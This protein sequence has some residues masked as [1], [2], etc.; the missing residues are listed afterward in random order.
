MIL[1]ESYK[2]FFCEAAECRNKQAGS[3]VSENGWRPLHTVHHNHPL[4]LHFGQ[5]VEPGP[6]YH[7]G[8]DCCCGQTASMFSIH[9]VV[10]SQQ[11]TV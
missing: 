5:W 9:N 8:L 7:F 4:T 10:Q 3:S 11:K 1:E 2:G 6:N